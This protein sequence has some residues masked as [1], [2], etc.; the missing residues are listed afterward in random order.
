MRIADHG[1]GVAPDEIDHITERFYRGRGR[2]DSPDQGAGLGLFIAKTLMEKMG[3]NLVAENTGA[4]LSVTL[5][6]KLC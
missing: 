3:G 5:M 2:G 4:G 6:I 1:P